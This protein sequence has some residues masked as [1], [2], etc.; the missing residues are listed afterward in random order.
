V[1]I[2]VSTGIVL[3]LLLHST[4]AQAQFIGGSSFNGTDSLVATWSGKASAVSVGFSALANGDRKPYVNPPALQNLGGVVQVILK[5]SAACGWVM[6]EYRWTLIANSVAEVDGLCQVLYYRTF[7]KD[8]RPPYRFRWFQPLTYDVRTYVISNVSGVDLASGNSGN[9][10]VLTANRVTTTGVGDYLMAFYANLGSG[11]WTS[12][13]NMGIAV[14]N[15]YGYSG[16]ANFPNLA[17]Q[18]WSYPAASTGNKVATVSASSAVWVADL[19]AFKP[20]YRIP[21]QTA[22]DIN[23]GPIYSGCRGKVTLS[24]GVGTFCNS[25]IKT[26]SFCQCRDTTETDNSCTTSNPSTGRVR[27]KGTGTDVE[28]INCM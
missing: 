24:N 2:R 12:P 17:T 5:S 6:P 3:A 27:L 9:G 1:K 8:E 23:P 11:D 26:T 21:P 22:G 10:R 4:S 18:A 16:P 28:L 13:S 15:D 25:C 7:Q 19:V 14:R 20:L